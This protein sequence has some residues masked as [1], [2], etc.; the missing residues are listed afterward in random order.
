MQKYY[1]EL[2]VFVY[3]RR[4]VLTCHVQLHVYLDTRGSLL[5]CVY[6]YE[7]KSSVCTGGAMCLHWGTSELSVVC[8]SGTVS[9]RGWVDVATWMFCV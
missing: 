2:M 7:G 9:L 1:V 8:H 5:P 3:S 4:A 6:E